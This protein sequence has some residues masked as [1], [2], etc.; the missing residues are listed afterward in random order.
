MNKQSLQELRDKVE[1]GEVIPYSI[2]DP[3]CLDFNPKATFMD[4]GLWNKATRCES[5]DVALAFLELVLPDW[6]VY[7]LGDDGE[8]W[9]AS[10]LT[11]EPVEGK[12]HG[13]AA[14]Q[15]DSLARALLL[16]TLEAL[17]ERIE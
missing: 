6:R 16:A 17:I 13:S 12:R 2:T 15:A 14:A 3:L 1:A 10:L 9:N 7:S 11:L 8:F 4:S 5:T